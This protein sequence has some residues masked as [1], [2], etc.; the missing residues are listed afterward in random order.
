MMVSLADFRV[1]AASWRFQELI[2]PTP[3][4][5]KAALGRECVTDTKVSISGNKK[6]QR[7]NT[8]ISISTWQR[9]LGS[10]KAAFLKWPG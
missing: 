7:V 3:G 1:L 6:S 4:L 5:S 9:G 2:V 10:R 8:G